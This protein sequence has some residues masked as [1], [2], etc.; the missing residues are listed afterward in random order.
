MDF[1]ESIINLFFPKKKEYVAVLNKPTT[2]WHSLFKMQYVNN[3]TSLL[4]YNKRDV[5]NLLFA[6]KYTN[7][8]RS[9]RIIAELL[10]EFLLEEIAEIEMVQNKSIVITN[11]PSSKNR[12]KEYGF[13]QMKKVLSMVEKEL[14]KEIDIH[15]RYV[16]NCLRYKKVHTPQVTIKNKKL[17]AKNMQDAFEINH[18]INLRDTICFIIDDVAT[19]GATLNE[20]KRAFDKADVQVVSLIAI[21]H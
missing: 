18:K 12:N 19:T 14:N 5:R 13:N 6:L 20:A 9:A 7:D 21:A 15:V 8:G 3:I 17:R 16:P 11:I 2:H 4:P 1:F 10:F